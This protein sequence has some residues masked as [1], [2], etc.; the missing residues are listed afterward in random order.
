LVF[1]GLNF[2]KIHFTNDKLPHIYDKFKTLPRVGFIRFIFSNDE[3][4]RMVLSKLDIVYSIS[5]LM[6]GVR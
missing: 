5:L 2:E 4:T 1:D 6:K 3:G